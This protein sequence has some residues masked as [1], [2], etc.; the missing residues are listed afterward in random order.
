MFVHKSNTALVYV[1]VQIY[2]CLYTH[3]NKHIIAVRTSQATDYSA[4]QHGTYVVFTSCV[5]QKGEI[6]SFLVGKHTTAPFYL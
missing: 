2:T 5:R 3:I 6:K 4:E 1:C